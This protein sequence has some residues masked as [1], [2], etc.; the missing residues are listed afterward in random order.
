M[1]QEEHRYNEQEIKQV[2]LCR[3]RSF[4]L[5]GLNLYDDRPPRDDGFCYEK[6]GSNCGAGGPGRR[7]LDKLLAQARLSHPV[8]ERS[9]PLYDSHGSHW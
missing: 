2:S 3:W 9:C 4:F 6:V 1:Y 7:T 5:V 8:D